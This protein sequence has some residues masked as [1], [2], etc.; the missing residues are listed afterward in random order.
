MPDRI[1]EYG[2]PKE[3][4]RLDCGGVFGL[5]NKNIIRKKV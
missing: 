5:V 2:K 1:T 4:A 3:Q